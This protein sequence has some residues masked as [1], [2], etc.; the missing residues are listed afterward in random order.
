MKK[1]V[2]ICDSI[3]PD[4]SGAGMRI[5]TQS[6]YLVGLGYE[7][8]IIT[9]TKGANEV[10]GMTIRSILSAKPKADFIKVLL[11]PLF[12]L[13]IL[14]NI[15][16]NDEV[17]YCVSGGT[18]ILTLAGI[19]AGKLKSKRVIVGTTLMH[20]DDPECVRQSNLGK[21]RFGLLRKADAFLSISPELYHIHLRTGLQKEKC[22]MIP[23]SV[24]ITKFFPCTKSE[25]EVLKQRLGFHTD[26]LII[27]SV[28]AIERRKGTYE[29]VKQ[30]GELIKGGA[31]D[32]TFLLIGP[33]D[34]MDVEA[35]YL[36]EIHDFIKKG[37][38]EERIRFLGRSTEVE[39][40]MKIADI[41]LFN[42]EKEGLPNV[43]I[44]AQAS[45]DIVICRRIPQVTDFIIHDRKDGYL[46]E[47]SQEMKSILLETITKLKTGEET[48]EQ[49]SRAARK[50]AVERF[51]H[52]VVIQDYIQMYFPQEEK[53]S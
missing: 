15:H 20:S 41:F 43:I 50:N 6:K 44:E 42:S 26:D 33:S 16:K 52:E 27:L 39:N 19:I 37:A 35:S 4:F 18:S 51:S 7:V 1:V 17:I 30:V 49:M 12:L 21:I 53:I 36:Q 34:T 23:N 32:I 25:K 14:K 3:P 10:E 5:M 13:Q 48:L 8:K 11:F 46:F 2:L 22:F 45:S 38:L 9:Q 47:E 29:M 40:Y 24:D 31:L 28:G